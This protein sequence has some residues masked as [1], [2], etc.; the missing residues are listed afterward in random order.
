MNVSKTKLMLISVVVFLGLA[1]LNIAQD[2]TNTETV[3]DAENAAAQKPAEVKKVG[4][5][6]AKPLSTF[7]ISFDGDT[8]FEK[9][10]LPNDN[11]VVLKFKNAKIAKKWTRELDTSQFK[12]NVALIK[13]YQDENDVKVV[14]QLRNPGSVEVTREGNSV[15]AKIE[16]T[17]GSA[18][19]AENSEDSD[20][21]EDEKIAE[22]KVDTSSEEQ[23]SVAP[24]VTTTDLT[25]GG[26][27]KDALVTFEEAQKTKNYQGKK[28]SLQLRDAELVDVFRVISEAS[29]FNIVLSDE[30]KG[31]ITLNLT[32][33]PWD[34]ALDLI[35]HSQKLAA[36]RQGNILRVTTLDALTKEKQAEALAKRASESAEPIVVKIFP[37]SYAN[38]DDLKK[39][40]DDFLS[41]ESS[42]DPNAKRGTIQS[43]SRTNSLIVRDTSRTIEKVQRIIKELDTQT[44]QILIEG[45]FVEV[46]EQSTKELQGRIFAT[47]REFDSTTG[48]YA[49]TGRRNAGGAVFNGTDSSPF[50]NRFAITP[51]TTGGASFGFMPQ[52]GIIPG[53]REIGALLNILENDTKSKIIASPRVVAQNKSKAEI[54]QGTV[55]TV[56]TAAGANGN[57]GFQTINALLKLEVTP[58]VTND[59]SIVLK[60]NFSQ[61]E[62]TSLTGTITVDSKKIDTTVLVDSGSTLVIGGIYKNTY[63]ED[64]AGIPFLRDIPILGILF[65]S[66][67]KA[68]TKRELFIFLT[69]RILNEKESGL[70][71]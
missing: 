56:P 19:T 67:K 63:I 64:S 66:N 31:K 57:G 53:I 4:F 28:I 71:G 20:K 30:V 44:P 59:G 47:S 6:F 51:S 32:D 24:Q 48:T 11:Q 55:L 36:E 68:I 21:K 45:K 5:S 61:D 43:D 69:P 25:N 14:F 23:K 37:I 33:V 70:R 58:Q 22:N 16:N 49:F 17:P 65:G 15:V 42:L 52:S 10:E 26:A 62:P 54:N 46:T 9:E 35:L 34:Q 7:E 41:K 27:E 8:S 3:T 18:S 2:T 38:I 1:K 29:D 40:L 39:V 13:S 50:P 60:V 12:S